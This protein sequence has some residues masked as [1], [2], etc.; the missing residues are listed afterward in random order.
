MGGGG[1]GGRGWLIFCQLQNNVVMGSDKICL[2]QKQ[3]GGG[4]DKNNLKKKCKGQVGG[5]SLHLTHFRRHWYC[6]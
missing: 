3:C 5:S 2:M 6:I 1:G 4:K